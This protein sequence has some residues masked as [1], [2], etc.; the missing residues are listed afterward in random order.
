MGVE[1]DTSLHRIIGEFHEL[2]LANL[3]SHPPLRL[4]SVGRGV[5]RGVLVPLSMAVIAVVKLVRGSPKG[6]FK[7][8]P[9]S[10]VVLQDRSLQSPGHCGRYAR[11]WLPNGGR[12]GWEADSA[13]AKSF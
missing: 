12:H 3:L 6:C 4:S 9:G 7:P 13:Q 11:K 1:Y 5:G 2:P 8:S 10:M